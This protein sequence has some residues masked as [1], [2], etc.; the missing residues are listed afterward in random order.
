MNLYL[1]LQKKHIKVGGRSE[2]NPDR[3]KAIHLEMS[4]GYIFAN[5]SRVEREDRC[6]P[7]FVGKEV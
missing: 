1:Y 2:D 3:N 5:Q 6:L 7:G 4:W